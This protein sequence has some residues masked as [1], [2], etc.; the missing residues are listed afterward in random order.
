[1]AMLAMALPILPGKEGTWERTMAD[2]AGPRR[3][4]FAAARRRQGI[5]RERIWWQH[6]PQGDLEVL[7]LETDDPARAFGEI[8]SSRE[9]FDVWFRGF[10]LEHYGID[11][12][13]PMP[14]PLPELVLDWGADEGS[15]GDGV[16]ASA[17]ASF[18]G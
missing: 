5:T 17:G 11:L 7:Y 4:E 15:T 14:G 8:A 6:T 2:L 12:S 1:M 3:A 10:V 16:G 13:Q 18:I 9:P